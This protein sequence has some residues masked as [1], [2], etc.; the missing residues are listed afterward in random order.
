MSYLAIYSPLPFRPPLLSAS[1]LRSGSVSPSSLKPLPLQS[2]S[3]PK[4]SCLYTLR[5]FHIPLFGLENTRTNPYPR[6]LRC[7]AVGINTLSYKPFSLSLR[8]AW[9]KQPCPGR[10]VSKD[11]GSLPSGWGHLRCVCWEP[12][13]GGGRVLSLAPLPAHL[14]QARTCTWGVR[15]EAEQTKRP[16]AGLPD[17]ELRPCRVCGVR[18]GG[19]RESG[20]IEP[21]ICLAPY[22]GERRAEIIPSAE[23]P[24][25][26]LTSPPTTSRQEDAVVVTKMDVDAGGDGRREECSVVEGWE[27]GQL[28][29]N[30]KSLW[31]NSEKQL[32][33]FSHCDSQQEIHFRTSLGVQGLRLHASTVGGMGLIPGQ[34]TKIPQTSWSS[35]KKNRRNIF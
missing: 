16:G 13:S 3:H 32:L 11:P 7:T 2:L 22:S 6:N 12:A 18:R 27:P 26:I 17:Y 20:S 15:T 31:D 10:L 33:L 34:G 8:S 4:Q 5:S 24:L 35:Q 30:P 23:A 25:P 1:C 9:R 19:D 14:H 29:T 21:S 28:S